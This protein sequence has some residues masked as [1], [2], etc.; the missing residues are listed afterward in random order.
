MKEV[1]MPRKVV[2]DFEGLY[3]IIKDVAAEEQIRKIKKYFYEIDPDILDKLPEPQYFRRKFTFEFPI[4]YKP[5]ARDYLNQI[6]SHIEEIER[7]KKREEEEREREIEL[8]KKREEELRPLRQRTLAVLKREYGSKVEDL[9]RRLKRLD[10]LA[11]DEPMFERLEQL[12]FLVFEKPLKI[13]SKEEVR[14]L[15]FEIEKLRKELEKT[16]ERLENL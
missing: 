15:V 8:G 16:I 11:G 3:R 10:F 14:S 13:T 7:E 12:K 9:E 4:G 2:L 1:K 6:L 5:T